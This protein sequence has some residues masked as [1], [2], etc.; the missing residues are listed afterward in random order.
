MLGG[1]GVLHEQFVQRLKQRHEFLEATG[2]GA[3]VGHAPCCLAV[4]RVGVVCRCWAGGWHWD[5]SAA[6]SRRKFRIYVRT[7]AVSVR[8][9]V[10]GGDEPVPSNRLRAGRPADVGL[11]KSWL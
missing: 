11:A 7:D 2:D 10:L 3:G 9:F 6:W 1:T 8:G 4:A 5:W